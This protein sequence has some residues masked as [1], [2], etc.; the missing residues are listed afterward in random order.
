MEHSSIYHNRQS[1]LLTQLGE[2]ILI[3][4]GCGSYSFTLGGRTPTL[5]AGAT[6]FVR[7]S[8]VALIATPTAASAA[9]K[10][11][12]LAVLR[13]GAE[14]MPVKPATNTGM[15]AKAKTRIHS[16]TNLEFITLHYIIL[17]LKVLIN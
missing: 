12:A 8:R 14:E 3:N 1:R 9:A 4:R 16:F 10:T 7:K 2:L 11:A 17:N 5:G 13:S 15:K 6:P